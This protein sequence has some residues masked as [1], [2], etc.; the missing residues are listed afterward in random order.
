MPSVYCLMALRLLTNRAVRAFMLPRR[1]LDEF[2]TGSAPAPAA[3]KGKDAA[4]K[5][6]KTVDANAAGRPW[7]A[8]ELR[9]MYALPHFARGC[10]LRPQPLFFALTQTKRNTACCLPTTYNAHAAGTSTSCTSCGGRCSRSAITCSPCATGRGR[11]APLS[12]TPNA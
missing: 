2:V 7:K 12:P 10:T 9:R 3:A 11:S 6:E 1:G 5:D 4:K 8:D